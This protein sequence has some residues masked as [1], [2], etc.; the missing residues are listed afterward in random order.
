[1]SFATS[2]DAEGDAVGVDDYAILGGTVFAEDDWTSLAI[3]ILSECSAPPNGKGL[4]LMLH[5]HHECLL[6]C[7]QCHFCKRHRIMTLIS[8]FYLCCQF[9]HSYSINIMKSF[10][11]VEMALLIPPPY[12]QTLLMPGGVPFAIGA[13]TA[14]TG[15]YS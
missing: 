15:S 6:H 13:S 3:H 2:C 4:M 14:G 1:M 8:Q 11:M 9:Y 5:R 12:F 10:A 7:P